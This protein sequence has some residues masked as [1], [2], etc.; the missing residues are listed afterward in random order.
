MKWSTK[1]G[2]TKKRH[3]VRTYERKHPNL[4]HMTGVRLLNDP[5]IIRTSTV[6]YKSH[7]SCILV[8]N[9]KV[10]AKARAS[11]VGEEGVRKEKKLRV[12]TCTVIITSA[13]VT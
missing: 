13:R 11:A 7:R 3:N 2:E 12:K 9:E 8:Q 5:K 10:L 4:P 6:K 1:R